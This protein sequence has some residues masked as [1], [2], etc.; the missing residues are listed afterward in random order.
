LPLSYSMRRPPVRLAPRPYYGGEDGWEAGESDFLQRVEASA[1]PL[2]RGRTGGSLRYR[3]TSSN[4]LSFEAFGSYYRLPAPSRPQRYLGGGVRGEMARTARGEWEW[5]LG[6]AA[7]QGAVSKGGPRLGAG[8]ALFP[9]RPVVLEGEADITLPGGRPIGELSASAGVCA[10]PVE[11]RAGW[12]AL[13][14]PMRTLSGPEFGL[15]L[16]F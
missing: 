12:R 6:G 9:G 15:V 7:L 5:V 1:Q 2:S 14:G 8:G 11:A 16:R 10:G 4:H 3:A 13:T